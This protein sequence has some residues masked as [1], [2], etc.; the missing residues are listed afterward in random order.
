ML[1]QVYS[2]Y[3]QYA[4]SNIVNAV[5]PLSLQTVSN[6]LALLTAA[7]ACCMCVPFLSKSNIS[8]CCV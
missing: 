1:Q 6:V 7:V 3:G 8:D 2:F 5:Q 4:I